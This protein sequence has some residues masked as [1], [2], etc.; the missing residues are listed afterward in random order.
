MAEKTEKATPKKLK[1][2]RKK[3]QVAKSQDFPSA[4][5]YIVAIGL[6]LWSSSFIFKYIGGFLYLTFKTA[7]TV[8]VQAMAGHYINE[9]IYIILITSLP[10]VGIVAIVGVLVSFLV[11]GP[12]F[13]AE[14]FKPEFKKFNPVENLKQKFKMRTVVELIKSILKIFGAAVLIYFAVKDTLGDLI[15]T[16]G[17][18][19]I[20]AAIVFEKILV[21]VIIWTGIYF[22]LIAIG[23]LVYQKHDFAKQMKMEKF[24]VKQEYKDTEGNPEIKG[25]RRQLAQEIAYD[26]GNRTIRRAKAIITNP[27]HIAV[28][29][30]YEPKR[31]A[32][33]WIIDMGIE[34]RAEQ[35]IAE[36][37][38]YNVPIMRNVPLAHQLYDEGE[39][40]K[41]VPENTYEAI[42]EILLYVEALK[43]QEEI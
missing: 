43:A 33:P 14:V 41:F 30:G 39:A 22:I 2:S 37:Q 32:A 35:I 42:G 38:R 11:I 1:D 17:L 29:I 13:S 28:A 10:I 36:A 8:N 18:P 20:G 3:G 27:T 34:K 5:T 19:P 31:Y 9:M 16:A 25:K 15:A 12:V 21:K 23:D 4:F 40:N 7:P 26:E 24:E 6:T